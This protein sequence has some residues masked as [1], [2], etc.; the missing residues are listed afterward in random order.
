MIL[1]LG[2]Q[3]RALELYKICING[4]P[5]LILTYFTARSNWLP[6]CLNGKNCYKVIKWKETFQQINR[7]FIFLRKK[8][9]PRGLSA[10]APGLYNT[11]I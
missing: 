7:R 6:A 3:H 1:K 4:D 10:P 11:C 8:I 5:V 9:N 2:M